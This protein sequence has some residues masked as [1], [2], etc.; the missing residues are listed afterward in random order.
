MPRRL[1]RKAGRHDPPPARLGGLQ[2]LSPLAPRSSTAPLGN[3]PLTVTAT[4]GSLSHSVTITVDVVD[5]LP[6]TTLAQLQAPPSQVNPTFGGTPSSDTV[7][8][9]M[10]APASGT[11][12]TL[13]SSNPAVASVPASVTIPA[14]STSAAFTIT[15]QPVTSTTAVSFTATLNGQT[16]TALNVLTV[17]PPPQLQS[18]TLSPTSAQP[19]AVYINGDVFLNETV[20]ENSSGVAVALSSSNPAAASV[21]ATVT[22]TR[23]TGSE[24]GR[25]AFFNV[26]LASNAPAGPVTISASLNGQTLTAQVMILDQIGPGTSQTFGNWGKHDHLL[27]VTALTNNPSD[28]LQ[29]FVSGTTQLIGT[30]T[31][32]GHGN[33]HGQFPWPVNPG[34]V[35]IKSSGGATLTIPIPTVNQ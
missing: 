33:Y 32:L 19:L 24:S 31:N 16:M 6:A 9:T 2:P 30:M 3:F 26:T 17:E 10:P 13:A 4:S 35:D 14:G 20:P 29:V 5:S 25:D 23:Y 18:L 7:L 21:P 34:Y 8:V 15:T 1:P 27:T 12:V 28:T 22:V 11:V